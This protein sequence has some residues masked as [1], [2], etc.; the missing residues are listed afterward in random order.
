M[1]IAAKLLIGLVMVI[2]IYIVLLETILFKTRGRRVF[3][4]TAEQADTMAVAMSNQGCYNGFL[5]ASL[6]LGL[7]LPDAK[8]ANAFAAYGLVCVVIAGIWGAVTVMRRILYIQAAPAALALV[9]L[10]LA[11]RV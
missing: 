11:G 6:A 7:L 5:A 8:I 10:Y 2:H 3:G 9:A 1:Q 4:M